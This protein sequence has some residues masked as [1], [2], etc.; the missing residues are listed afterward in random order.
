MKIEFYGGFEYYFI[1]TLIPTVRFGSI[2]D[3]ENN[4][5][6]IEFEWIN[7]VFGVGVDFWWD[8]ED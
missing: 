3:D 8:G 1:I 4:R 7:A 2:H 5:I 6:F